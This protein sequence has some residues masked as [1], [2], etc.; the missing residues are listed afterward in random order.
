[1]RKPIALTEKDMARANVARP[2]LTMAGLAG[3][4]VQVNF[5]KQDGTDRTLTGRITEF[6]GEGDKEVVLI[7]TTE[8]IRS[9]NL[10][11][12]NRVSVL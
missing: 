1:M 7:E 10:W 12:V 3:R 9:A 2:A 11:R 8:G 6:K 5:T 4:D